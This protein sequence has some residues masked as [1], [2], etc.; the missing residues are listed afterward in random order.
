MTHLPFPHNTSCGSSST[1]SPKLEVKTDQWVLRHYP[2]PNIPPHKLSLQHQILLQQEITALL[3]K[4]A[5]DPSFT[6]IS[7]D[8]SVFT[9]LPYPQKWWISQAHSRSQTTKSLHNINISIWSVFKRI[10]PLLQKG[11]FMAALDLKDAYFQIPNLYFREII[12][13]SNF[14]PLESLQHQEYSQRAQQLWQHICACLPLSR[15]LTNQSKYIHT[16]QTKHSK[17]SRF[18]TL[19]RVYCQPTKISP[20]ASYYSSISRSHAQHKS[21]IPKQTEYVIY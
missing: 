18:T 17:D 13:S 21:S 5:I 1:I 7:W 10:I 2:T 15:P 9:I 19:T 8:M 20:T 11:D 14:F 12:I 6:T 3:Q 4:G 16:L